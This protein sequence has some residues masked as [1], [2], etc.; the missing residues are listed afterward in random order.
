MSSSLLARRA[1][2]A[3]VGTSIFGVTAYFSYQLSSISS[4]STD[5]I[6]IDTS[7][8]VRVPAGANSHRLSSSLSSPVCKKCSNISDPNRNETFQK[9]AKMY[10]MEISRE[11]A[12]MGVQLLRRA[13]LYFHSNGSVLEVAGGTGRNLEY[14]PSNVDK[15]VITDISDQMLLEGRKK[16]RNMKDEDE[17]KRF[18]FFVADAQNM[19][20]YGDDSFDTIVDTFG[21][22]SFDDP[23]AVLKELQRICKPNGRILLLEHG[24]SKT[25]NWLSNYLDKTAERHAEN[26]G[27]VYNRDIDRIL[28]DSGIEIEKKDTY[29][30]GTTYYAVCRPNIKVKMSKQEEMII[31]EDFKEDSKGR[32]R[33]WWRLRN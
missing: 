5:D 30:F 1:L 25:W 27:C 29:H 4:S 13:L 12:V 6:D 24:R 7:S 9:N 11:E 21:L 3:S 8:E 31:E 19:K 18:K 2:V 33:W 20:Y 15:I 10:D 17:K 32:T 22:C 26:W 14:Y 16:V 23:V 28:K